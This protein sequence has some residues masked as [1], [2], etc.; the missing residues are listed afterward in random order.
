VGERV[1]EGSMGGIGDAGESTSDE[2]TWAVALGRSVVWK[3]IGYNMMYNLDYSS[4]ILILPTLQCE[5]QHTPYLSLS[6]V[7]RV[8][9]NR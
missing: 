5:I 1:V 7:I 2:D 6:F 3:S 4:S 9:T 8:I